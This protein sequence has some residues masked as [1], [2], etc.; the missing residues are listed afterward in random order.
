MSFA[1]PLLFAED[2]RKDIPF[3][4]DELRGKSVI[5][6]FW[7]SSQEQCV[8]DFVRLSE[9]LKHHK[10]VALLSVNLDRT[11]QDVR[12]HLRDCQLPGTHVFQ[13]GG[14]DGVVA[15]RYGIIS[16]PHMMLV[17]PNGVVVRQSLEFG[18]LEDEMSR[19]RKLITVRAGE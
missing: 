18:A 17:A 7:A 6:Y 14:L 15:K 5:V 19:L 4:V 16:L 3:D 2:D 9:F 12:K 1:L 13:R 10:D 8:A 11:P